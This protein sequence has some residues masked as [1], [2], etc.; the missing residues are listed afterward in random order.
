LNPARHRQIRIQQ[1]QAEGGRFKK[2]ERPEDC[3]VTETVAEL[4]AHERERQAVDQQIQIWKQQLSKLQRPEY[5]RE[6]LQ[7]MLDQHE[8]H[9]RW[10]EKQRLLE[11]GHHQCPKCRHKWPIAANQLQEYE[12]VEPVEK[13]VLSRGQIS[14]QM[15]RHENLARIEELEDLLEKTRPLP[16][17]SGD[18]VRRRSYEA[19][20][21]QYEADLKAWKAYNKGLKKKEARFRELEGVPEKVGHLRQQLRDAQ[22]FETLMSQYRQALEHY[23]ANLK[24][25]AEIKAEA[26]SY[27]AAREAIRKL[28]VQVKSLLLP[29][30]NRVAS[31]LLSQ[32]TGGERWQ[33]VVDDDF[34]IE[35]D[36]QPIN[37]LSGSGKAVANLAIRIALGQILTN[38]VFSVFIA[39]EVDAAMD[40]ERAANTA[41][42]LRRLTDTVN[43]VVLVTHKSPETD[44]LIELTK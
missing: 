26:D 40:S 21:A 11:Q 6:E 39:D 31:A 1:H 37:T 35:I 41:Q 28:K 8:A 7:A 30:L 15:A 14:E 3:P 27:F 17:R 44:H 23:E 2:P 10:R 4:L 20:L 5:A 19:A 29:S 43:Q 12:N 22:H 25:H 42:A 24:T 38:R 34:N 18:L 16:D 13:P 9:T 36:G 33:V 32:M